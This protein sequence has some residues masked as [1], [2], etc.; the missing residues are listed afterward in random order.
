MGAL[1]DL[2]SIKSAPID[3]SPSSLSFPFLNCITDE[4]KVSL[5]QRIFLDLDKGGS[6]PSDM[7]GLS[8]KK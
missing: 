8:P 4:G 6:Y 2:N 5:P 7:P 3:D 1:I